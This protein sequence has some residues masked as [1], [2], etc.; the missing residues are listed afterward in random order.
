MSSGFPSV[1]LQLLWFNS[2][3]DGGSWKQHV[4]Y[5]LHYVVAAEQHRYQRRF[6]SLADGGPAP[7]CT[8]EPEP[9][10]WGM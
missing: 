5:L 7:E 2:L 8:P 4:G 9:S 3:I 1:V 6:G 10:E